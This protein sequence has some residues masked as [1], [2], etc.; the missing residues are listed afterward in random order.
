MSNQAPYDVIFFD[1][2]GTL[3]PLEV[4]D[5]LLPYYELMQASCAREGWDSHHFREALNTGIFSMYDHPTSETNETAFWR[6]FFDEL[7]G[8]DE[9]SQQQKDHLRHF[10]EEFY[11]HEF[12]KAGAGVVPNPASARALNTLVQ[13]GYPLYLTTMPM[14]PY[15][16]IE[17]RMKWA[18]C[19]ISLFDR[20]TTFDNST[21]VKPHLAYYEENIALA[22]VPPERI[23]MVGNNTEDDLDCMKLDMDAY[24]VTD[25]LINDNFFDVDEVKHGS[26]EEFA[27]W[28]ESLPPCT[29][30]HALGWRDRADELRIGSEE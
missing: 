27:T 21:A 7:F 10:F 28:V 11:E 29:S 13:K 18:N 9:P 20:V 8:G 1:M 14:F 30:T 15:K 6:V 16:A 17:W 23:L 2:D 19:D 25:Y 26:M 12:N 4:K 24:L 22:D 3:L 5:F